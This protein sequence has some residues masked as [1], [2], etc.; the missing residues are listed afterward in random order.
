MWS[1]QHVSEAASALAPLL[2]PGPNHTHKPGRPKSSL[3]PCE[4]PK[5]WGFSEAA[6][7]RRGKEGLDFPLQ[8]TVG[9]SA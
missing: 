9:M 8:D 5:A 4:L 1:L 2:S 7:V 6:L 3:L